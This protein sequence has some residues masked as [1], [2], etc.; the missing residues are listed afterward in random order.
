MARTILPSKK[1][2]EDTL[3]LIE[4]TAEIEFIFNSKINL[5]LSEALKPEISLS[6]E[7]FVKSKME[8]NNE[9]LTLKFNASNL[10]D[11]RAGL[12]SYIHLVQ[13]SYETL[14]SNI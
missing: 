2:D 1:S 3:S 7:K 11:L 5:A 9:H 13:A 4:S 6:S 12:N 14:S 8:I 10:G